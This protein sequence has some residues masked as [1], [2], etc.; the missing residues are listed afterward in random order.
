MSSQSSPKVFRRSRILIGL[1]GSLTALGMQAS[2]LPAPS[3]AAENIKVKYGFLAPSIP[4]SDLK[5]YAETGKA[6]PKLA[7]L[8]GIAGPKR[9]EMIL[10]GL[11]HRITV[12]PEEMEA[13]L[14]T[15]KAQKALS[16]AAAATYRPNTAGVQALK[17]GLLEGSQDP[18]GLGLISFLEAYPEPT[19]AIDIRKTSRLAEAN[20]EMLQDFEEFASGP[21]QSSEAKVKPLQP[22]TPA[23]QQPALFQ[24]RL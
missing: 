16:E 7:F 12:E 5:S 15:Q 13:M 19:L 24:Q 4:V 10:T 20:R 21:N 17:E 22:G 1:S 8:L 2:L 3:S 9:Q 6:T 18:E 11:R 14:A 23:S